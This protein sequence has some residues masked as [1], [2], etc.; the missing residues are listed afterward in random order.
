MFIYPNDVSFI[1][2]NTKT[3]DKKEVFYVRWQTT[4]VVVDDG[5]VGIDADA[6]Y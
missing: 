5:I 4:L 1:D 2:R 3:K 6:I